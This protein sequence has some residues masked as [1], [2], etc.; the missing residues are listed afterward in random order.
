MLLS[1][2]KHRF[3]LI[4]LSETWLKEGE[5]PLFQLPDYKFVTKCRND[6]RG[7]GVGIYVKSDLHF[8]RRTDLEESIC[9]TEVLC[10]EVH[11]RKMNQLV[12]V[13]YR[14]TGEPVN[15]F[16]KSI[17]SSLNKVQTEKKNALYLATST[18]TYLIQVHPPK[19]FLILYI[20]T[21]FV[22]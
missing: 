14:P 3:S 1:C 5:G 17:E 18:L 2:F 4:G 8:H 6:R 11:H 9:G 12:F 16:L 19:I 13:M 10:I 15:E 20:H 22:H 21:P 7:G